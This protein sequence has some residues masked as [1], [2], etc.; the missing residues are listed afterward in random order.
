MN[1]PH[2]TPFR[3]YYED[4]DAGGVVYHTNYLKF[5]ERA[6]TEWLRSRGFEQGLLL[7]NEDSGFAVTRLECDFKA[8]GRLDDVITVETRLQ[9]ASKVRMRLQ[10]I[11]KRGATPL[12]YLDVTVAWVK[13]GKPARLPEMLQTC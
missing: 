2:I 7:K 8:P 10:Q 11:I 12:V 9:E 1:K 4:T 3:V 6:R 5:A 13:K